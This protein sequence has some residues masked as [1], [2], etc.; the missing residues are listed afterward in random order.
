[1]RLTSTLAVLVLAAACGDDTDFSY[2]GEPGQPTPAELDALV[3]TIEIRLNGEPARFLV[4]TGAPLTI[5]NGASFPGRAE[6]KARDEIEAFGLTFADY[7]T[8]TWT[9]FAAESGLEGILGGDLLRHF[10]FTIDYRDARV[11]LADPFDE[12]QHPADL[13]LEAPID[14]PIEV[15]GGGLS[16]LPGCG[17]DCGTVS[18]PPTRVII[19][20][21]FEGQTETSWALVDSGASAVVI[22]ED[23]LATLGDV[24][25][26]PKLSGVT[27]GTVMGNID[28]DMS[29]VWRAELGDGDT[30][31][32]L[33]DVP[34][35]VLP[36][37]V[38]F[39]SISLEV[40]RPIVALI[41]GSMLRRWMTTFDYQEDLLR[42]APY[43]ATDHIPAGE[44]IGVGFRL[45]RLGDEYVIAD[46]YV[47][48]DAWNEGL[49]EFDV[50]ETIGG[51]PITGASEET[52]GGL[53]TAYGLGEEVPIG[54]RTA[55][56][57]EEHLVLVEDLLPS[58]PAP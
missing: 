4:D 54:I 21:R 11:W 7:Q 52:V 58:Y 50:V 51:T 23:V 1:M 29:R 15:L 26:R 56:G 16:Y 30:V 12:T 3:P 38:F 44:Y 10:A 19:P 8:A 45:Q 2:T 18:L 13:V 47:D 55:G 28:A 31:A 37:E 39:T 34:V 53:M 20:V 17:G 40:G 5:V 6:G 42:L 9:I 22:D 36:P 27:V 35:L 41:G 43:A 32:T 46:V 49:A 24:S 14:V 25:G 57:T 48:T 33:D